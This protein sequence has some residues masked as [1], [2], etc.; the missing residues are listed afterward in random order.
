MKPGE[1]VPSDGKIM[2]GRTN[3]DEAAITGESIPVSK[4]LD[5]EVFAGTVN[6]RG[7][8]TVEITKPVV[9]HYFK[10]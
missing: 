8:I 7:T 4:S 5:D 10:K 3:L 2:D 6:L 9:K 1:R